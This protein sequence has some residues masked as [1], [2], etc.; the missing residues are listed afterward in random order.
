M[1]YTAPPN[2]GSGPSFNREVDVAIIG[3]TWGYVKE[4]IGDYILMGL[5][6]VLAS[7]VINFSYSFFTIGF[8]S[9]AFRGPA[10]GTSAYFIDL[11]IQFVSQISEGW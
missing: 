6:V 9:E 1:S 7:M 2:Y 10:L 5:I 4:K 8:T 11:A 3:E